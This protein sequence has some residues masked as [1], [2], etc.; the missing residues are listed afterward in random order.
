MA[1]SGVERLVQYARELELETA[2]TSRR[3]R[4][5]EPSRPA[6]EASGDGIKLSL[7]SAVTETAPAAEVA[8]PLTVSEPPFTARRESS[9]TDSNAPR[10][11]SAVDVYQRQVSAPLGQRIAIR[12]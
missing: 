3:A 2:Q 12:A 5:P 6:S 8:A 9:D 4:P 1:I 10:R 7:S 11:G